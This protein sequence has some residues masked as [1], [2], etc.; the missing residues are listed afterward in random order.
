MAC[1]ALVIATGVV[2]SAPSREAGNSVLYL[3]AQAAVYIFSE[4]QRRMRRR[5]TGKSVPRG[6]EIVLTALLFSV[7]V[8]LQQVMI[9]PMELQSSSLCDFELA[10]EAEAVDISVHF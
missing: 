7:C 6:A 4:G 2:T 10:D 9:S 3:S 5:Q 1:H 8:V